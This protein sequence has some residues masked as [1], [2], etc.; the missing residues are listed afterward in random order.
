ILGDY[1]AG[2]REL[3]VLLP[4]KNGKS[5]L[6]AA[7]ALHHVYTRDEAECIVGAASREQAGIIFRAAAGFVRRSRWLQSRMRVYHGYRRVDAM[8]HP[9]W[10]H[11]IAADVDTAD[12]VTPTLALVDELHRHKSGA[13]YGILRDGLGP[14]SGRM[15][16]ISTAGDTE[17]S[18]LGVL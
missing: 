14:R 11:V 6:L 2:V 9:G 4:K 13:L 1:F 12:G 5:T 15:V 17:S 3:L 18:P 8:D 10:L 16:T 7:L